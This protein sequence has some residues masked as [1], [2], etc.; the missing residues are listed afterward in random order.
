M[1]K[2][3]RS[4][5]PDSSITVLRGI[6]PARAAAFGR[7]GIGTLRDLIFHF[8][9]GYE[10]RGDIHLLSER[11][12]GTKSSFLLTVA[13]QPKEALIRKNMTLLKFR[14]FDESGTIEVV[15]FN[16]SYLKNVFSVGDSYRFFGSISH[17]KN[18]Y[19]LI[20]PAYEK[21]EH[22]ET[23]PAFVPLYPLTEGLT[24]R[25]MTDAIREA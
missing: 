6:G 11:T 21:A 17:S 10:N 24:R 14:A 16:Q 20:S 4:V 23:L 13:T 9:R 2:V 15:F 19:Q 5:S 8:P 25:A 7:L 22:P 18:T 12:D 3:S 1:S